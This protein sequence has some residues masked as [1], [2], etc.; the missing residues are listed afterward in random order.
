M[1][2]VMLRGMSIDIALLLLLPLI[3]LIAFAGFSGAPWVP[4]RPFDVEDLLDDVRVGQGTQYLELGCGDGRLV[5]AAA[6][7][8]ALAVGYE[9]NPLLWLVAKLRCITTG[10]ASI[11]FGNF[12]RV[13]LGEADVV[14]VFLVPRTMP[15][16]AHKAQQ[17]MKSKASLVSYV[18]PVIGQKSLLKRKSWLVYQ[19][20]LFTRKKSD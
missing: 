20:A 12:W 18:F 13:S 6:Q 9:L 14:M 16:L 17:E 11:R 1:Q 8:G 10:N 3:V 15:R 7:R 2:G 4:V 19:P 5:K